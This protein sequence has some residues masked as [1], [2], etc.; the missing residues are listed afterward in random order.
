MIGHKSRIW[1]LPSCE[2]EFSRPSLLM[3]VDFKNEAIS[4]LFCRL[5]RLCGVSFCKLSSDGLAFRLN[6]CAISAFP[7]AFSRL[8]SKK[9]P[10]CGFGSC[11]LARL[12]YTVTVLKD[13]RAP[14]IGAF[15]VGTSG[16]KLFAEKELEFDDGILISSWVAIGGIIVVASGTNCP[17]LLLFSFRAVPE[18]TIFEGGSPGC[19]CL[20]SMFFRTPRQ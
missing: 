17:S 18:K 15:Q 19:S 11:M 3:W 6:K 2:V 10:R 12:A 14:S 9:S 16:V 5:S 7:S 20:G 4:K 13:F 1:S 8:L